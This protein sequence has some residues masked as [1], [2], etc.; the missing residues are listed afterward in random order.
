[1]VFIEFVTILLLF[2]ALV[3][4]PEACGI[5]APWPGI[6]P[7]PPALE[8]K[9]LTTGPPGK[10]PRIHSLFTI[11]F[12]W[13]TFYICNKYT[14]MYTS[15]YIC[16]VLTSVYTCITHTT[17]R[18]QIIY[19]TPESS[20]VPLPSQSHPK[21]PQATTILIFFQLNMNAYP[22]LPLKQIYI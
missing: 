2:C 15:C 22:V 18:I 12:F 3:F 13:C 9:V 17:I 21:P 10:P 4:W 14:E 20:L 5:L 8:G 16:W 7:T 1:M 19:I 11:F 6:E